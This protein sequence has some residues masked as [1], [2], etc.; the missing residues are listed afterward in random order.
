MSRAFVFPGQASQAVGMGKELAGAFPAAREVFEEIDDALGQNLSK[1][2][3][4]GPDDELILTENA[5]PAI[6]AVSL[7]VMR[8]LATEG[9]FE[10]G[11]WAAFVAGHS[12]GEY[13][14]L[15]AAGC[16]PWPIRRGS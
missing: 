4:E 2:M 5:Q 6:M 9:G 15:C 7:A 14:A 10:L 8:V 3:F 16:F 13:S 11:A 1:L 12:L